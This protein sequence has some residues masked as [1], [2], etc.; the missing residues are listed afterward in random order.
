MS[1]FFFILHLSLRTSLINIFSTFSPKIVR[2]SRRKSFLDTFFITF[3]RMN[4]SYIFLIHFSLI[5][6]FQRNFPFFS[7]SFPLKI[8]LTS[9]RGRFLGI[10]FSI[11]YKYFLIRFFHSSF[12]LLSSPKIVLTSRRQR[13]LGTLRHAM[14]RGEHVALLGGDQVLPVG[15]Q[16]YREHAWKKM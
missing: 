10:V 2:T 11:F 12:C 4:F 7:N 16:A 9:K 6:P 1:T 8:V 15:V 3:F 13:L 5:F 14:P